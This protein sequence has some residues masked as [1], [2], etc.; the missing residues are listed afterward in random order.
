MSRRLAIVYDFDGVETGFIVVDV[1]EPLAR[2]GSYEAAKEALQA[3]EKETRE[4]Q[5]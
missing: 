3:L 5:K 4:T 2:H 1:T